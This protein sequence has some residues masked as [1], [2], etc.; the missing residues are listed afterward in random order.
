MNHHASLKYT[1]KQRPSHF[2]WVSPKKKKNENY[3]HVC[4]PLHPFAAAQSTHHTRFISHT[5]KKKIEQKKNQ[6][7]HIPHIHPWHIIELN[8]TLL[9]VIPHVRLNVLHFCLFHFNSTAIRLVSHGKP[10]KISI[11]ICDGHF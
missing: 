5:H 6:W 1:N 2:G 4:V 10:I 8:A 3:V 7:T 11:L 9:M